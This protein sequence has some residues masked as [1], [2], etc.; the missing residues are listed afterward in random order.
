M[1]R[2]QK[3]EF[4]DS[5]PFWRNEIFKLTIARLLCEASEEIKLMSVGRQFVASLAAA[6]VVSAIFCVIHNLLKLFV[7]VLIMRI[8]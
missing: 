5:T 1:K 8:N 2:Y 7:N 6:A 4:S 3:R